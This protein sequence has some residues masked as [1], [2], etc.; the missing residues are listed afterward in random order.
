MALGRLYNL[1][2]RH[3][4]GRL[5][6]VQK[7][8]IQLVFLPACYSLWLRAPDQSVHRQQH[9]SRHNRI[10]SPLF[11]ISNNRGTHTGICTN[12]TWFL[13]LH[14]ATYSDQPAGG[15]LNIALPIPVSY[16]VTA[17]TFEGNGRYL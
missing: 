12:K 17:V 14:T 13:V 5:E 9:G 6:V 2:Y 1:D 3:L 7:N 8:P 15:S 4:V 11:R 16:I 10:P